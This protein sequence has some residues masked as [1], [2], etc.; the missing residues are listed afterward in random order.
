MHRALTCPVPIALA[1]LSASPVMAQTLAFPGAEGF[2]RFVSGGRGGDVYIVTNLN[3]SGTGSLRE[4]V[5]NRNVTTPRTIVFAVSGTIFLNSPLRITKGNLT[6]AGQTA[7]GDGICLA[8]Y[9]IDPGG[10]DNV[11]IRFL[12]SR[13]GDVSGAEGDAF[14]CRY[15]SNLIIDHCSFSWSVDETS[16]P[17]STTT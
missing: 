9:E 6:I 13:H 8:N 15:A 16:A 12:R 7:P 4:G 11:I 1:L 5:T 2:G 17:T 10:T 3:D 14:S